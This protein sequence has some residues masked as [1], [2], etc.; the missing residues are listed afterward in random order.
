MAIVVEDETSLFRV[1]QG[2]R[3]PEMNAIQCLYAG[4]AR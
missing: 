4:G 1:P 2:D 3:Q